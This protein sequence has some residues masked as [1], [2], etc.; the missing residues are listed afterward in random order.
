M[1]KVLFVLRRHEGSGGYGSI[2]SGL[3]NSATFVADMLRDEKIADTK[4]VIVRDGNGIDKEIHQYK[5]DIVVLEAI[6]CPPVKLRELIILYPK[7]QWVIRIH[8]EISFLANEGAAIA[9]IDEYSKT[10][11]TV[12]APN[13]PYATKD[14][15]QFDPVYLPNYYPIRKIK[16]EW[17]ERKEH[18]LKVGCFGAIRPMK[19]QL[20]QAF[21]AIWFCNHKHIDHL[22]FYV[23]ATRTEQGGDQV[24]KNLIALFA[25]QEKDYKLML[26]PWHGRDEFCD[27][28][29]KMDVSMNVS[30]SET[31][32]I[33]CANAVAQGIPVVVSPEVFWTDKR[34]QCDPTDIQEMVVALEYVLGNR[35]GFIANENIKGLKRY[36]KASVEI[37]QNFVF[38]S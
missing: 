28:V 2:S 26:S 29:N 32:C 37:W 35:K 31:F 21:A 24:L 25:A 38:G 10:P 33:T 13:S 16:M 3:K 23:N 36:N 30:L 1:K 14:L 11:N 19:N 17:E 6:W 18:S 20:A 15:R 7:I 4:V 22:E 27:L 9:Y 12:I 5:P 8:S 34:S